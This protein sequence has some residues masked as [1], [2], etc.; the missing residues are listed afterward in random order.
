MSV[1]SG[2]AAGAVGVAGTMNTMMTSDTGVYGAAPTPSSA[3]QES[4]YAPGPGATMR[5]ITS[6]PSLRGAAT[7]TSSGAY[8]GMPNDITP[9]STPSDASARTGT[10]DNVPTSPRGGPAAESAY[11]GM[12]ADA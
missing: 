10:L 2:D 4:Y 5:T 3:T 12:P 6:D 7:S 9:M 8:A 1:A 11:A